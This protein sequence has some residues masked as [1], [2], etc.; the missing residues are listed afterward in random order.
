MKVIFFNLIIKR[1]SMLKTF[2]F[3][4]S[5]IL[6]L[7]CQS[8][9]EKERI[10]KELET[11]KIETEYKSAIKNYLM[12]ALNDPK[13]YEEISWYKLKASDL[14]LYKN[15]NT[16]IINHKFRSKNGF[17]G[18]VPQNCTFLFQNG[19]IVLL[20]DKDIKESFMRFLNSKLETTQEFFSGIGINKVQLRIDYSKSF[21]SEE[22]KKQT[23]NIIYHL[24]KSS[25]ENL[26][27]FA[28]QKLLASP[29]NGEEFYR[30][31][32]MIV[33]FPEVVEELLYGN[34][35]FIA[36]N[37][38]SKENLSSSNDIYQL[39]CYSCHGSNASKQALNKS[40]II[41]GWSKERITNAL[42]GYKDGTYGGSLKG[43]MTA[44][45]N[46]LS[47]KDIKIVSEKIESFK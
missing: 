25:S 38:Q 5:V 33:T 26:M 1:N 27:Q 22:A 43:V 11:K 45:A 32:F 30:L 8:K 7:G 35:N 6:F 24:S 41:A 9:E 2:I 28:K 4:L 10:A 14:E 18:I 3:M 15:K 13:S 36:N 39:K 31:Y 17:G 20:F 21:E 40:A 23:L 19:Q 37:T 29:Y 47:E 34:I 16:L 42:N 44:I 12:E 46:G